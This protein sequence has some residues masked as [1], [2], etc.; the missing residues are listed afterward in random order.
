[1]LPLQPDPFFIVPSVDLHH[2]AKNWISIIFFWTF[3]IVSSA[4]NET[5]KEPSFMPQM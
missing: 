2:H 1:M 3:N 5:S 4:W